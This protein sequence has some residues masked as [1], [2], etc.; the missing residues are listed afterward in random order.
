M[1]LNTQGKN[2]STVYNLLTLFIFLSTVKKLR[3]QINRVSPTFYLKFYIKFLVTLI[4]AF[5]AQMGSAP[6]A[7][8]ATATEKKSSKDLTAEER[9]EKCK[10]AEED[11]QHLQD[12]LSAGITLKRDETDHITGKTGA[13]ILADKSSLE[14]QVRNCQLKEQNCLT[15]GK[16]KREAR[17]RVAKSCSSLKNLKID[18]SG[19]ELDTLPSGEAETSKVVTCMK[20]LQTCSE[21]D[22]NEAGVDPTSGIMQGVATALGGSSVQIPASS[23]ASSC[24]PVSKDRK[25]N[26]ESKQDKLKEKI[27]DI[28]D[29]LTDLQIDAEKEK[30]EIQKELRD[31]AKAE[32]QQDLAE[33]EGKK[34]AQIESQKELIKAQN[35]ILDAQKRTLLLQGQYNSLIA[36]RAYSLAKYSNSIVQKDCIKKIDAVIRSEQLQLKQFEESLGSKNNGS[37]SLILNNSTQGSAKSLISKNASLKKQRSNDINECISYAKKERDQER[38]S[39]QNIM[40]QLQADIDSLQIDIKESTKFL[41][42]S[43]KL[44]AQTLNER[45]Q[46]KAKI[47]QE[48][49]QE[50]LALNQKQQTLASQTQTKI[51]QYQQK[52]KSRQQEL[53]SLSNELATID[54]RPSD[55]SSLVEIEADYNDYLEAAELYNK[56]GCVTETDTDGSPKGVK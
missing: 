8:A 2:Y 4:F 48:R 27:E 46:D 25:Q 47:K 33:S 7:S 21:M 39:Y 42:L 32:R 3:S 22:E 20:R 40:D 28:N 45:E 29:E 26:L 41:E 31:M 55:E 44:E 10:K 36:K 24:K 43:K 23:Y 53:A 18:I 34:N 35:K 30:E 12:S 50:K 9:A 14:S 15:L 5:S 16:D 1:N 13:E 54:T 51:T 37:K 6:S 17:S 49:I 38:I 11:L 56:S 52:I 19:S